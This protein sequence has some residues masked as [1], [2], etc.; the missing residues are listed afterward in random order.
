GRGATGPTGPRC[1]TA[2]GADSLRLRV[3][4]REGRPL[5]PLLH[6]PSLIHGLTFSPDGRTL[7]VAGPG[8]VALWDVGRASIR[9]FLAEATCARDVLFRPDGRQLAVAYQTG[10]GSLG[11]AFRLWDATTARPVGPAVR[12]PLPQYAELVMAFTR[13]AGDQTAT[14]AG[15]EVLRVFVPHNGACYTLDTTSGT[16][17]GKPLALE[18]AEGA[19]FGP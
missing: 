8:G 14:R 9:H 18:P 13:E 7:A 10:L 17:R 2:T 6:N 12:I 16:L 1:A 4:D 19:A 5:T 11:A 15:R 3:W